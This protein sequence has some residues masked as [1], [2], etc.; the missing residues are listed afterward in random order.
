MYLF[1]IIICCLQ[2]LDQ[3]E[4]QNTGL[5]QAAILKKEREDVAAMLK[6]QDGATPGST[7]SIKSEPPTIKEEPHENGTD[8]GNFDE[9]KVPTP[10]ID[11]KE[12]SKCC[13]NGLQLI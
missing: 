9:K 12:N 10:L 3:F 11:S 1:I 7:G 13:C 6:E 5:D 4:D 8:L 2:K